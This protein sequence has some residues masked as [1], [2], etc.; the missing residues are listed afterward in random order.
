MSSSAS[1]RLFH[2]TPTPISENCG[3]RGCCERNQTYK[4]HLQCKTS[5]ISRSFYTSVMQSMKIHRKL[6]WDILH[7]TEC[8]FYNEFPS[9]SVMVEPPRRA[10]DCPPIH[11]WLNRASEQFLGRCCALSTDLLWS[12][13]LVSCKFC[14]VFL[15]IGLLRS[16]FWFHLKV[17]EKVMINWCAPTTTEVSYSELIIRRLLIEM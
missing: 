14:N 6:R 15:L 16:S 12:I 7:I 3:H 2:V 17:K 11:R 10:V 4:H 5:P 13:F 8:V 1:G 9:C